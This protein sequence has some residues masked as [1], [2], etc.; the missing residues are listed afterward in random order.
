MEQEEDISPFWLPKTTTN[1]HRLRRTYSLLLTTTT[2]LFLILIT[3]LI[4]ILIVVPTIYSFISN[5]FKFK[6]QD[7]KHSWDYLNLILVLF[8]VVCG[9]LTKNDTNET[10]TTPRRFDSY[11]THRRSFSNPDTETPP[12]WYGNENPS[13]F[14]R[15][16]SGG[17]YPDLRRPEVVVADG[18]DDR[19]RF[20]DDTRVNF[21]YRYPRFQ[22][23]DE[24]HRETVT[25]G[26]TFRQPEVKPVTESETPPFWY[27][28]SSLSSFNRLR[29][30]G[31]YSDLRRS[32]AVVVDD[33]RYRFYDDTHIHFPYRNSRLESE[34][35]FHRE[36]VTSGEVSRR[37]EVKPVP[38]SQT[39]DVGRNVDPM[40]EV[41]TVEKSVINDSVVENSQPP[42]LQP[43][44]ALR[45]KKTRSASMENVAVVTSAE[46]SSLVPEPELNPHRQ[47]A[48]RK[49]KIRSESEVNTAA[50]TSAEFSSPVPEQELNPQL[51]V[52]RTKGVRGNFKRTN[53]PKAIEKL[54]DNDFFVEN[55]LPQTVPQRSMAERKTGIPLKKKRGNATK[56]FLAS[57][58]GKK[59]KQRSKSVE[60][61]ETIQNSQPSPLVSQPPPPPPPPPPASVFHNLFTSNKSKHKK[62][63]LVPMARENSN[64][65]LE[66]N[67]VMTGN[68][69]PL[70]PIPPP[71][72]PPPFKLPAWKFRVQGDYVRVDS[73]GS[74]RS[75][76]P[77]SDEVVESP[78][79]Q[80]SNSPYAE[81][82]E[83]KNATEIGNASANPL[84]C[85]SP[86]VDTKAQNF[87]QNFRAGLR[88]AKMNSLREKQGIGRSNLGPLQNPYI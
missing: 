85:P 53:Q 49:K 6:P 10:Q 74:S 52:M 31:S 70:I 26:E 72:P 66:K 44:P 48:A 86:D 81:D 38:D 8:A 41:E 79:S 2:T 5:I 7:V 71:P 59:K 37:P 42:P 61:F 27:E 21:R 78:V 20:Y 4:F 40:Y 63:Y 82:G 77:D 14:N 32:E 9:F 83:E 62:T 11:N 84:F 46:F 34:D 57:L 24:F 47:P 73:I 35:E 23:E 60:N 88:M 75:G 15:L 43:I 19:Y 18:G 67:V 69:S 25:S 55:Y 13:V 28:N 17:S 29:S 33:E 80:C 76:S 51:P 22:D 50:V 3:I 12:F 45:K 30:R 1:H 68:E 65:R 56:E 54:E 36:K 39:E 58:R 64:Y 16:R 87:I